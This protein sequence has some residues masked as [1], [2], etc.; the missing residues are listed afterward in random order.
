MG[1]LG[2]SKEKGQ[3]EK[4]PEGPQFPEQ[5]QALIGKWGGGGFEIVLNDKGEGTVNGAKVYWQA[6]GDK[7]TIAG[8]GGQTALKD[9]MWSVKQQGGSLILTSMS[10]KKQRTIRLSKRE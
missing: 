1:L 8:S 6:T 3:E 2:C 9:T 5:T 10:T 7:V 4:G